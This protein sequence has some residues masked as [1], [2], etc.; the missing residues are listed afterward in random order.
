MYNDPSTAK[1]PETKEEFDQAFYDNLDM[2][3]VPKRFEALGRI[4]MLM[5]FDARFANQPFSLVLND[6]Y[7]AVANGQY[8]IAGKRYTNNAGEQTYQPLAVLCWAMLDPTVAVIRANNIRP[9]APTEYNSGGIG[10]FTIFTSPF[11]DPE[12][13][14]E[15]MRKKSGKLQELKSMSFVD[16]LFKPDYNFKTSE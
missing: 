4:S 11:D 5:H 14:I 7:G 15:V 6:I 9:L 13:T 16:N 3:D 12:K 1:M 2:I 8:V 10:F